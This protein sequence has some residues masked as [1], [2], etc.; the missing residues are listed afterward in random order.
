MVR[1]GRRKELRGVLFAK[2][3]TNHNSA[4]SKA[5]LPPSGVGES[6]V[7]RFLLWIFMEADPLELTKSAT[8][9]KERMLL[10]DFPLYRAIM[11]SASTADL[12]FTPDACVALMAIIS[13][14]GKS[15]S[16]VSIVSGGTF[17]NPLIIQR[18]ETPLSPST[19]SGIGA[20]GTLAC[21]I[22]LTPG[23]AR[24][25]ARCRFQSIAHPR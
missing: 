9:A 21:N 18:Y 4:F 15:R 25:S 11:L 17:L 19:C 23:R 12:L 5:L 10:P 8:I 6:G 22:A 14:S 20:G 2:S 3:A 1:S 13:D 7:G 24:N 16:A